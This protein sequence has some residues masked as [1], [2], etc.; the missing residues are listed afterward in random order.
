MR[1]R[2]LFLVCSTILQ[3]AAKGC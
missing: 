3:S 2:L 1:I